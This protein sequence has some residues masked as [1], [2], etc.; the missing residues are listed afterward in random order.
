M[1]KPIEKDFDLNDRFSRLLA[2][3]E[4]DGHLIY[5]SGNFHTSTNRSTAKK[6]GPA[7]GYMHKE[8]ELVVQKNK[9]NTY[10]RIAKFWE[11]VDQCPICGC[12]EREFFLSRFAIDVYRCQDCTHN[13][14]HPRIK[15][16]KLVQL[17]AQDQTA[18]QIYISKPQVD[19]D[20]VKSKYGLNILDKLGVP[21]KENIMD[22]GCGSGKF[23]DTAVQHGWKKCVGVDANPTFKHFHDESN[24]QF[25]YSSFEELNK[26]FIGSDY[27]AITLWNVL[28]HLYDLKAIVKQLK[29]ILKREGLLF[30]MVPNVTSL[31]TRLIRDKSPTFNWKHVAHFT[32]QSLQKLMEDAGF[33]TLLIET[34]ISEIENV[35]SYMNGHWPYSGHGD[36]DHVFD[37]ISPQ[38]IDKHM[39]G[40]RLIGVF[41]K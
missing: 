20:I 14:I 13:Y 26:D 35:K 11:D 4:F 32:P 30:I 39:M 1:R 34:A 41:R 22:L 40:S 12:A 17:Y 25:I 6:D 33:K 16:N 15:F 28:E 9:N 10:K 21:D 18:H 3:N 2:K 8:Q 38:Y 37:V 29:H 19:I 5:G 27:S 7:D 23:L 24:I 31:A 36:P